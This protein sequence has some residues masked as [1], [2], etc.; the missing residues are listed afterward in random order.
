MTDINTFETTQS[1]ASFHN[2]PLSSYSPV[3]IVRTG[4]SYTG[5][6]YVVE[7]KFCKA[8]VDM[9]QMSNVISLSDEHDTSC[10]R[11]A[12]HQNNFEIPVPLHNI[13]G[14]AEERSNNQNNHA[15]ASSYNDDANINRRNT[16]EYNCVETISVDTTNIAQALLPAQPMNAAPEPRIHS[17]ICTDLTLYDN[18]QSIKLAPFWCCPCRL[19]RYNNTVSVFRNKS[20]TCMYRFPKLNVKT[21]M[22]RLRERVSSG[23]LHPEFNTLEARKRNLNGIIDSYSCVAEAGFF[24]DSSCG[25]ERI[26]CFY[27]DGN[28]RNQLLSYNPFREHTRWFPV[29][30]FILQQ[31]GEEYIHNVLQDTKVLKTFLKDKMRTSCMDTNVVVEAMRVYPQYAIGKVVEEFFIEN[32]YFPCREDLFESLENF[33]LWKTS[34]TYD[35]CRFEIRR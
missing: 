5:N 7:C 24:A 30:P 10:R 9:S 25:K 2:W 8:R 26:C 21:L 16:T 33:Q 4:F 32:G 12:N 20:K 35:Y 19:C 3:I 34:E 23:P 18:Y 14:N 6:G 11:K 1:L 29:C 27:C 13:A 15:S 17:R 22:L 31:K 28:L